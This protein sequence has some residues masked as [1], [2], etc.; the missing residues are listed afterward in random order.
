VDWI[1]A[2]GM[3]ANATLRRAYRPILD[4]HV[5]GNAALLEVHTTFPS[6]GSGGSEWV[7]EV[8]KALK[9]WEAAHPGYQAEL[10]GGAS[11]AVDMRSEVLGSMRAYLALI[12]PLI[13]AVV[14]VTFRSVM[15][16]LRLVLA[17]F[18]TLAATYGVAVIIYQTPLLHGIF[19]WLA[20]FHGVTYEVIPMV[21]GVAIALG[22]DYDIFLVSRIVEYRK[23]G[24][25][26]RASVFR[27]TTKTGGIISGAGIIMSLAFS[28]LCFSDK[29]LMQQFGVLL[30]VSVLFDTFVVRTILVPAMMLV[31]Q[32][33][34][35]W[36]RR[37]PP[38]IHDILEGDIDQNGLACP[39]LKGS[40][41]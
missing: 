26:D 20:A 18:F 30:I 31:A 12:V 21:T 37:M 15:V 29:L 3:H 38:P 19:P 2:V 16:P 32:R 22:L 23:L 10:S 28:G 35:W 36:P 7:L 4:T 11:E 6:I 40:G 9:V 8:R 27:G 1:S 39:I 14:L 25:S 34:N 13:M 17:L 41:F 24:F 33:W 5:N